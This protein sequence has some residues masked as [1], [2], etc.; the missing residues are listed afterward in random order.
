MPN[1]FALPVAAASLSLASIT[2]DATER[3][4]RA[5]YDTDSG[6]PGWQAIL[7]T[8]RREDVER[9][10]ADLWADFPEEKAL[11]DVDGDA[12]VEDEDLR[13]EFGQSD[14]GDE[15]RDS[16][17]PVMNFGWAV[18]LR[19]TDSDELKAIAGRFEAWGLACSLIEI[20]GGDYGEE[21][22][23]IALTG[24]GMNLSDHLA[25]AYIACGH[26]PPI[27]LLDNLSGSFP[28]SLVPRLPMPEVI[29]RAADWLRAKADRMD[30]LSARIEAD[31]IKQEEAGA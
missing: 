29:E 3:D 24:G 6:E 7:P 26:V 16:F 4:W 18:D 2:N 9:Y 1:L 12:Q 14:G 15:W 28:S 22:Y 23:E 11:Y 21:T 17:D 19:Y 25:A 30:E 5:L 31:R 27:R 10:A 13:E 20:S 8:V